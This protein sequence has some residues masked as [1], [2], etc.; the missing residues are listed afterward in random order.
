MRHS[1]SPLPYTYACELTLFYPGRPPCR[2]VRT[3]SL[4]LAQTQIQ[5]LVILTLI[6]TLRQDP[7][8]AHQSPILQGPAHATGS[9]GVT[10][11]PQVTQTIL[12]E[13]VSY[14]VLFHIVCCT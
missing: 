14:F 2:L 11:T 1:V 9:G 10:I 5:V 12:D 7:T 6:L 3:Q 4:T 8:Q 13:G